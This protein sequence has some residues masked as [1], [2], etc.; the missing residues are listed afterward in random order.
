MPGE[1]SLIKKVIT[2]FT[3]AVSGVDENAT[4]T[5]ATEAQAQE[6]EFVLELADELLGDSV[7]ISGDAK[8]EPTPEQTEA[9]ETVKEMLTKLFSED[10]IKEIA[11]KDKNG[12]TI[13]EAR[14]Y[15]TSIAGGDG[16]DESL[17][18]QD[19]EKALEELGIDPEEIL[20]DKVKELLAEQEAEEYQFIVLIALM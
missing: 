17:S 3:N 2:T 15:L 8:A 9:K 14:D 7:E 20:N 12:I 1:D 10:A 11:D 13:D 19:I 18:L 5:E 16:D 6:P 4:K